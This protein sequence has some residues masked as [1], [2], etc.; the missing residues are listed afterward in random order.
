[1]KKKEITEIW[2]AIR[3]V[4]DQIKKI[5]TII[6]ELCPHENCIYE[7][8]YSSYDRTEL[9]KRTCRVC[10]EIVGLNEKTWLR[11]KK[12]KEV[13]ELKECAFE[14]GYKITKGR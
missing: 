6:K 10:G 3:G 4:K 1:M 7:R 5:H 11:E 14:L 13:K 9:Y 8:L 12:E 2:E